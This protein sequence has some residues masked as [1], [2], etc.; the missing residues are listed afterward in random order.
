MWKEV[1]LI[2]SPVLLKVT[3]MPGA[4]GASP[5][6]LH[7]ITNGLAF[8]ATFGAAFYTAGTTGAKAS[9][10]SPDAL[11]ASRIAALLQSGM[12]L[13]EIVHQLST[14][15]AA[16]INS[17]PHLQGAPEH[18]PSTTTPT[19]SLA[20]G[21]SPP[22]TGPPP[23][24][25]VQAVAA[26]LASR[27]RT[28][29][30]Q[31]VSN[32]QQAGQ[33]SRF[34]GQILDAN[35]AKDIPAQQVKSPTGTPPAVDSALIESTLAAVAAGLNTTV[36]TPA[37][38]SSRP[39]LHATPLPAKPSPAAAVAAAQPD[40][41]TVPSDVLSR[42]LARAAGAV[43]NDL[44]FPQAHLAA[45]SS[46]S[47]TTT[48]ATQSAAPA[49]ALPA[50]NGSGSNAPTGL[51]L[52]PAEVMQRLVAAITAQSGERQNGGDPQQGT[53]QNAAAIAHTA[54]V[55]DAVNAAPSGANFAAQIATA[56]TT[57]Q[58]PAAPAAA[59]PPPIDPQSVIEQL[60]KSIAV[61]QSAPGT[62]QVRLRLQPEHLGDVTLRLTVTGNSVSANVVAQNADV[63]QML[64]ASQ[65]QLARTL[66]D[67]G[68]MLGGFSVD[69]SGGNPDSSSQRQSPQTR[70][71]KVV[72]AG[73]PTFE[74]NIDSIDPRTGPPL[75]A[76]SP[77][78]FSYLA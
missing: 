73:G 35:S 47:A 66:A 30:A 75:L 60:V 70:T 42:M 33:Q 41:S 34:S 25:A 74:E 11:L 68:L 48:P 43:H 13:S 49:A 21:P 23:G 36:P 45:G 56:S 4:K 16:V 26:G 61:V 39:S 27:T 77:W 64:M 50:P 15:I 69:V 52:T 29:V 51:A 2:V 40:G 46:N 67:A 9:P 53:P 38:A 14:Q 63:R 76:N 10:S 28:V 59:A 78:A 1:N 17:K 57:N 24:A 58:T 32:L 3:P 7:G 18:R 37:P 72:A 19:A 65:P 12:P 71:A 8:P 6:P 31:L 44:A 20:R 5:L 54:H 22:N 55:P 62:S